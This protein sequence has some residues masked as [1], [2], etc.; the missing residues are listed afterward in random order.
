MDNQPRPCE[1]VGWS[2][3]KHL[4]MLSLN[5]REAIKALQRENG[6]PEYLEL[7]QH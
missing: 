5:E 2:D 6:W 4:T 1:M 7:T 3:R